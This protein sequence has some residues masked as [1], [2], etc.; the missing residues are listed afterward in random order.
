MSKMTVKRG[1]I[2]RFREYLNKLSDGSENHKH[3]RYHQKTRKYGDY[4]Y[5]QDRE[6]FDVDMQEWLE[7]GAPK[8]ETILP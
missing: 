5:H 6:K 4:M 1:D 7:S 8:T 3:G 2:K